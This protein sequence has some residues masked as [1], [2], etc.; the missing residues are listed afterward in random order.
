MKTPQKLLKAATLTALLLP[1]L[2]MHSMAAVIVTNGDVT[3]GNY[4]F[5]LSYADLAGG[6]KTDAA[7]LVKMGLVQE[8]GGTRYFGVSGADQ[9]ASLTYQ[10]DFSSSDYRPTSVD[11][12]SRVTFFFNNTSTTG[13]TQWSTNGS[14]WTTINTVT[15]T[16]GVVDVTPSNSVSLSGSPTNVYYRILFASDAIFGNNNVQFLRSDVG[17]TRYTADFTVGAVPEPSTAMM[18][19]AGSGICAALFLRRR[20]AAGSS[21]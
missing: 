9:N 10:W 21:H 3:G 16:G 5:S 18:L 17:E 11:F 19:V 12:D 8:G 13:T 2:G 6:A 4:T 15:G 14:S 7:S 20:R 1:I